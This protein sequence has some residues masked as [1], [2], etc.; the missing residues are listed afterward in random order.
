SGVIATSGGPV[1]PAAGFIGVAGNLSQLAP[2]VSGSPQAPPRRA[3]SPPLET[4]L[5]SLDNTSGFVG[6][7]DHAVSAVAQTNVRVKGPQGSEFVLRVNG[8]Q[9]SPAR[10][11]KKSVLASRQLQA[12]EYFGVDS[13][14]GVNHS[15]V[16][17]LD[18]FGNVRGDQSIDV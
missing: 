1:A 10:V 18:Q 8:T 16:T 12:W 14:P 9:I 4:S 17:S 6:M 13:K 3:P 15:Q 11:G 5:P 2:A 7:A